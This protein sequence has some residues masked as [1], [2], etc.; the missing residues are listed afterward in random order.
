M[1]DQ[2]PPER[3][4]W[5]DESMSRKHRE[6]GITCAAYD[7]DFLLLE[8]NGRVVV[9]VVEYKHERAQLQTPNC[10]QYQAIGS[11]ATLAL[12]PFFVVRYAH[13]HSWYK[14]RVM[15]EYARKWLPEIMVVMTEDEYK[16]LMYRL[17]SRQRPDAL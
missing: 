14:V 7:I 15:N 9:A 4:G 3:N 8:V 6:W 17:R 2:V 11:V 5:R 16:G 10:P 1:T 13:D 12:L